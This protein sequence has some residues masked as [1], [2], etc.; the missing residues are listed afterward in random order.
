MTRS[1]S[2]L[3]RS[4]CA[5]LLLVTALS[6]PA[7]AH[8]SNVAEAIPLAGITIDGSLD[9]WPEK[10]RM[11][12]IAWVHPTAYKPEPP[13]GPGDF[14]ARFAVGFDQKRNV[15]YV[16]IVVH[17][18]DEICISTAASLPTTN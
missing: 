6:F 4:L 16:A 18:D 13:T 11:Y 7:M 5:A 15:L 10:M 2:T 14:D 1:I 12:P 17:D 3:Q 8:N 9:D